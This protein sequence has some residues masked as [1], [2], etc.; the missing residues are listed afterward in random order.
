M[1]NAWVYPSISHSTGK[2]NKTHCMGRTWEIGTHTLPIWY[3]C[4]FSLDS[5]SMVYFITWEMDVFS[6]HLAV[7][8]KGSQIHRMGKA[9]EIGSREYPTK[10]IVLGKP[11]K[12]AL[13]LFAQYG[14]FLPFDCHPMVYFITCEMH[15]FSHQFPI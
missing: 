3:G 13:I 8:G 6:H 11:G 1:G 2:C 10:S 15:G 14:F 5:H 7:M 12:L 9:W 4:F